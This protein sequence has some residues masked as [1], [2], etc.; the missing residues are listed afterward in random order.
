[1]NG[2]KLTPTNG[3][4]F[5]STNG[6]KLIPTD[7]VGPCQRIVG[8]LDNWI[9]WVPQALAYPP[10][11]YPYMGITCT[12]HSKTLLHVHIFPIWKDKPWDLGI[13]TT[14]PPCKE[15]SYVHGILVNPMMLYKHLDL[16]SPEVSEKFL[17]FTILS[18]WRFSLHWLNL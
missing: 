7:E 9:Y 10:L 3:I 11:M 14:Y 5:T 1:M 16:P 12:P 2:T 18:S 13:L 4:E 8:Y 17:A 15:K 6:I